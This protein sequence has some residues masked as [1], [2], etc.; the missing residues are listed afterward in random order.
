MTKIKK[1]NKKMTEN[2]LYLEYGE[3]EAKKCKHY[4][5]NCYCEDERTCYVFGDKIYKAKD[6]EN[7]EKEKTKR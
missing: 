2:Q 6:C 4:G 3:K 5:D 7:F 1:E